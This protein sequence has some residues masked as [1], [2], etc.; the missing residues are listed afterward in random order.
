[1]LDG[2]L[3]KLGASLDAQVFHDGVFVKRDGARGEMQNLRCFLH[4][5]SLGEQL[6]HF[7]LPG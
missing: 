5:L 2:V 3:H 6:E 4:Q 7:A 1:M